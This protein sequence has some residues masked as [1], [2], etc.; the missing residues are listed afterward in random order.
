[1]APTEWED[2]IAGGPEAQPEELT[3]KPFR[4]AGIS[5]WPEL[6]KPRENLRQIREYL[7]LAVEQGAQVVA[8]CEGSLDGYITRDLEKHRIRPVDRRTRGFRQRV[9]RFRQRQV[10]LARRIR[11]EILPQVR[12]LAA[13]HGVYLF[14]GGLDLRG[15]RRVYNTTFVIDPAGELIGKY[16]KVHARFEVVNALGGGFPVFQTP[17]APIGVLI[18]A[19]RQAPETARSVALGGA[20]VLII[21]SYGMWGEGHNERFIRQRAYENGLFVLFCHPGETVLV[22]PEGRIIAATC[23]WEHVV[24]RQIDPREAVGRGVFGSR[25]M[26]RAYRI[27]GGQDA[28]ARLHSE[29][30]RRKMKQRS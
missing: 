14:V 12:A 23:T 11:D 19:D 29:G 6:W 30:L 10:R 20:R 7:P 2:A 15:G 25:A 9:A 17:F 1:V 24:V 21:N 5:F 8:T 22:S 28:Y 13:E 27:A 3:M 18:C 26:A 16:D 4:I